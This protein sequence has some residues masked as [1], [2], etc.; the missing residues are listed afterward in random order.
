M[1]KPISFGSLGVEV[2]SSMDDARARPAR[3]APFRICILGDFSGRTSRGVVESLKGR[4]PVPVDRDTVDEVL[5]RMKVRVRLESAGEGLDVAFAVL[6]DFHP[7]H[8]FRRI[9][10][11]KALRDVR[12]RLQDTRTF[13]SALKVLQGITGETAQA[14]VQHR[15]P[16]PSPSGSL[17]DL[18]MG[19]APAGGGEK[20]AAT[21]DLDAFLAAVVRPHLV[22]RED[23][24][25]ARLTAVLDRTVSDLMAE[26]MHHPS[27]QTLEA[28]WRG[29]QFLCSRIETDET[30][31]ICLLDISAQ[32]LGSDLAAH[33]D[34]SRTGMYRL[35][36]EDARDR[37]W[38][39]L[40]GDYAFGFGDAS[41]L[42]RMARVAAAAG[43]PFIARAEP[44]LVGC[45]SLEGNP[46]PASWKSFPDHETLAAWDG[47]RHLREAAYVGLAMPRF[48]LRLPFGRE[49]DAAET[50]DFEEMAEPP[51]HG[52]Y[53]WGNPAYACAYLLAR[54]FVLDG[55]DMH[56]GS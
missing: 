43:A 16:Q 23:P 14:A 44:R 12:D 39:V 38:A 48:L 53:L 1:K 40:I 25:Q 9:G 5:A 35:L 54:S 4:A 55:W 24:E 46:D 28:S 15:E 3:D 26:V 41:T 29:V 17:L 30:L 52:H 34:L 22:A 36:V 10:V 42:G 32:E 49:T 19:E 37:P 2:V 11:F 21:P 18:M 27:F 7:D 50:F 13:Q 51:V 31:Q 45:A 33:E 20:G 56:P 6:D 8:L 47:L